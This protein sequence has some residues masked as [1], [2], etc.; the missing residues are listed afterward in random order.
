MSTYA[1]GRLPKSLK[2]L[3][4]IG[5]VGVDIFLREV[6]VVW[7][8]L[9]PLADRR[10][11]RGTKDLELA[12]EAGSLAQLVGNRNFPRQVAALVRIG[13]KGDHDGVLGLTRIDACPY[14]L[15]T[16]W[17]SHGP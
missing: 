17:A 9:F 5:G 14:T 12:D 16:S 6:Q 2:Q 1:A 7:N 8:Q 10:A 11:L 15:I 4:G 3:K 13:L